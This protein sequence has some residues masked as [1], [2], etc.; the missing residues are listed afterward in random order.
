MI[1]FKKTIPLKTSPHPTPSKQTYS[2]LFFKLLPVLT[3]DKSPNK[4]VSIFFRIL[5]PNENKWGNLPEELLNLSGD[6]FI[7]LFKKSITTIP[8]ALLTPE[9]VEVFLKEDTNHWSDL[10]E[11]VKNKEMYMIGV[12]HYVHLWEVPNCYKDD[13]LIEVAVE[14]SGLNLKYIKKENMTE[15]LIWKG[16]A[17]N[18]LAIQFVD[19][20]KLTQELCTMAF[21]K[22]NMAIYY[23]PSD[24]ITADMKV[25]MLDSAINYAPLVQEKNQNE[26]YYLKV[27]EMSS[28]NIHSIPKKL[29]TDKI[30]KKAILQ[31]PKIVKHLDTKF[32]TEP[33]LIACIE[34]QPIIVKYLPRK[35]QTKKFWLIALAH[36]GLLLRKLPE[37][38]HNAETT[39]TAIKNTPL[40]IKY[41]KDT[42]I[43]EEQIRYFEENE[44]E[45][46]K[47]IQQ[48]EDAHRR[49]RAAIYNDCISDYFIRSTQKEL[50][51]YKMWLYAI[52]ING[53]LLRFVP[54][55]HVNQEI[56]LKALKN[57]PLALKYAKPTYLNEDIYLECIKRAGQVIK[58]IPK[59]N[60]TDKM[61][62][63]A[64]Q[65]NGTTITHIDA[66]RLTTEHYLQAVQKGRGVLN[67]I[68]MNERTRQICKLAVYICPESILDVPMKH[69]DEDFFV[70]ALTYDPEMLY[71]TP[72]YIISDTFYE[73]VIAKKLIREVD[74]PQDILRLQKTPPAI[75]A[76]LCTDDT[77]FTQG[78]ICYNQDLLAREMTQTGFSIPAPTYNALSKIKKE[79]STYQEKDTSLFDVLNLDE[80]I[81]IEKTVTLGGRTLRVDDNHFKFWKKRES[82]ADF[83]IESRTVDYLNTHQKEL[84][85]LSEIP[86]H[87]SITRIPVTESLKE[88]TK[89]F[90]DPP[91]IIK[92]PVTN[93]EFYLVYYY[94]ASQDYGTFA[95]QITPQS[96]SPFQQAHNGLLKGI[97]DIGVLARHG[98]LYTNTLPTYHNSAEGRE[99][100]LMGQMIK[101]THATGK[102]EAW[103]TTATDFPDYGYSGLR[104]YGDFVLHGSTTDLFEK[105]RSRLNCVTG[106]NFLQK[107]NLYNMIGENILAVLLLYARLHRDSLDYHHDNETALHELQTFITQ[108]LQSFLNGYF[109][110][111]KTSVIELM[112]I[113]SDTYH[114]WLEITSK[115]LI[116]W[117]E[118]QNMGKPCYTQ[119]LLN[120]K[121]LNVDIYPN[122]LEN[123]N[124][125]IGLSQKKGFIN[126][127]GEP[128]LGAYN[129]CFPLMNLVE[130]IALFQRGIEKR[131]H[132]ELSEELFLDSIQI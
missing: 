95:H 13:K 86:V 128:S 115:R 92:D 61:I 40:A 37:R 80:K 112:G 1:N 7:K 32:L 59:E 43:T 4:Q 22:N 121:H 16:V 15:S 50:L 119:D 87:K 54:D 101:N 42:N 2:A 60:V 131:M 55:E 12:K 23:I 57:T 67:L 84:G 18:P 51:T 114:S 90:K 129:C 36:N 27:I 82:L 33:L 70:H 20:S 93:E 109:K 124:I 130:G 45:A 126:E 107:A 46:I 28:E 125:P 62:E 38:L 75:Q 10:P 26:D 91:Y 76:L 98:I 85:L 11:C 132:P 96:E 31:S 9:V 30:V 73:K 123:L 41:A 83:I 6:T 103:C 66:T 110:D 111:E 68:P 108:T 113:D 118:K 29:I 88:K 79:V 69:L 117:T 104:D 77:P 44:D 34:E 64:I 65:Q 21:E 39:E 102:M 72:R 106:W 100:V 19:E 49:Y 17:S 52:G 99:W 89:Q 105:D 63:E 71:K 24:K 120:D 94:T 116:Y 97:H 35:L 56:T 122:K 127:K 81:D 53:E 47:K 25:S 78:N 8:V 74:I 5:C 3:S 58:W 14:T 48:N